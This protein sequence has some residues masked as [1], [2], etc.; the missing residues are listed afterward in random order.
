[1]E[2]KCSFFKAVCSLSHLNRHPHF[3]SIALNESPA[4]MLHEMKTRTHFN[5]VACQ[6]M[7]AGVFSLCSQSARAQL[8]FSEPFNYTP[9]TALAGSVNAGNNTAW[10]GGNV[11]ELQ[12]GSSDLTYSGL[13]DQ[14]GNDLVYTSS[15]SSSTSYNTYTAVTSGSIYYSFL[16]NCTTLPTANEYISALNPGTTTPGGSSDTKATYVGASGTGWK[17]GVRTTGGGSGAAYTSALAL[18]TTYFVVEEL[19]LGSAPV[20]NL[21]LDPVPGASQPGTATATQST[22]TAINSVAD[23]GFKVQ[24]T[25]AT[26]NFIIDNLLI[27]QDWADVTPAVPEP[28]AFALLGLGLLGGAWKLRRQAGR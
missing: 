25:A 14:G 6:L 24:S 3:A 12:I 28:S 15:A 20:A 4:R 10:T 2:R 13:V 5:L 1:M 27:A 11:N 9:G 23:V 8:L 22:A 7:A 16:I 21:Y 18:N 19:T 17:I 26:G